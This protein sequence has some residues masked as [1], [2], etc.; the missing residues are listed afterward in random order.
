ML[1][2]IRLAAS[3][4]VLSVCLLACSENKLTEPSGEPTGEPAG[5]PAGESSGSGDGSATGITAGSGPADGE[6]S[7][8]IITGSF[9]YDPVMGRKNNSGILV[10]LSCCGIS[11]G[12]DTAGRVTFAGLKAG[13]YE[14]KAETAGFAPVSVKAVVT[15]SGKTVLDAVKLPGARKIAEEASCAPAHILPYIAFGGPPSS[16]LPDG[17]Y[18]YN[19]EAGD[20]RIISI[21]RSTRLFWSSC[22]E[23]LLFDGSLYVTALNTVRSLTFPSCIPLGWDGVRAVFRHSSGDTLYYY[24]AQ[25]DT[26]GLYSGAGER[27]FARQSAAGVEVYNGL[28]VT[29]IA[30]ARLDLFDY[31]VFSY[32]LGGTLGDTLGSTLGSTLGG[33]TYYSNMSGGGGLAGSGLFIRFPSWHGPSGKLAFN[34]GN[35]NFIRVFD[36]AAD[37]YEDYTIYGS[38]PMWTNSGKILY[39][40][41]GGIYLAY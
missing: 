21:N 26:S 9:Y 39:S 32:T 30:G 19:I 34:E 8:G 10:F 11:A 7:P 31:P 17:T 18:L 12:T 33:V 14:L 16:L 25:E 5:E 4:I 38:R 6:D 40:G 27:R 29:V 35:D 36:T 28:S 37:T 20:H 15:A 13:T 23:Y 1:I 41:P 2:K 24:N 22:D 3:V